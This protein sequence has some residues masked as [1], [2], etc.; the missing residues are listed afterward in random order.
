MENKS[1]RELTEEVYNRL[2]L[3]EAKR[4]ESLGLIGPPFVRR[5]P[6]LCHP[7]NPDYKKWL[8]DDLEYN[9]R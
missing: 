4:R 3:Q 8:E 7:Q 6:T 9:S 5:R 1:P 2:Y